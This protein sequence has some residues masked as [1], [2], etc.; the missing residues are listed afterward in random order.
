MDLDAEDDGPVSL[1]VP[2]RL[3]FR[4]AAERRQIRADDAESPI[5]L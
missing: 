2:P 1:A 3:W 5:V 4:A